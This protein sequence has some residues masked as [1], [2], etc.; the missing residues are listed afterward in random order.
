MKKKEFETV[1]KTIHLTD[2]GFMC[3]F[4]NEWIKVTRYECWE[5]EFNVLEEIE[6][7]EE[8]KEELEDKFQA[9]EYEETK[10]LEKEDKQMSTR[11]QY[12]AFYG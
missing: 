12:F 6:L 8:Q 5:F 10:Q 3:E 2:N 9:L 1:L 11:E 7:S 4:K